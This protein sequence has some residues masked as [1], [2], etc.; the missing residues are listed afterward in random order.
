MTKAINSRFKDMDIVRLSHAMVNV[1]I[2][3]LLPD[4]VVEE[5][6]S[7]VSRY[8][9]QSTRYTQDMDIVVGKMST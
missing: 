9:C 8:G 6:R 3:Q 4:G 5:E 1:I 7:L 2:G